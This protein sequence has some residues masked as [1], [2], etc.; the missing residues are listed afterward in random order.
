MAPKRNR[1]AVIFAV[2]A[3]VA[4]PLALADSALAWAGDRLDFRASEPISLAL[5]G[6][7]LIGL[8]QTLVRKFRKA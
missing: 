8:S 6:L 4:A 2:V 5:I 3:L 1:G 7:G